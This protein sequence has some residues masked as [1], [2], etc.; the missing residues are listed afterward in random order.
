M[1][2][3]NWRLRHGTCW[4]FLK[5]RCAWLANIWRGL[6]A[7]ATLECTGILL[8]PALVGTGLATMIR[9]DQAKRERVEVIPL[10]GAAPSA[11]MRSLLET[12]AGGGEPHR[13][14]H[15]L[16]SPFDRNPRSPLPPA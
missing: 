14:L 13:R 16:A 12:R 8:D 1:G 4:S 11:E 7:R 2:T 10:P 15:P 5:A 3:R 9:P 6:S